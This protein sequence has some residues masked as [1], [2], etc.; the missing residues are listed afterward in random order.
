MS[1]LIRACRRDVFVKLRGT[2]V[3]GILA[4]DMAR[5]FAMVDRLKASASLG[6]DGAPDAHKF[7]TELIVCARTHANTLARSHTHSHNVIHTQTHTHA[8]TRTTP[9]ARE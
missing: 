9:L 1:I 4:T 8:H 6:S 5:H 3:A 2:I 7:L